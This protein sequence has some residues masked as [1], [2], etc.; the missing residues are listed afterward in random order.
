MQFLRLSRF[1]S[2]TIAA[3]RLRRLVLAFAASCTLA[4]PAAAQDDGTA[5]IATLNGKPITERDLDMT[6]SDLQDQLGQVPEEGRRAAAL[7]ALIDIRSLATKAEA[8]GMDQTDEFKDRMAFLRQ[9][10]LHNTYFRDEIVNKVTDEEVR[11]RYDK[12]VAATPPENEVRARH[13]LL[14]TE[15]EAK[16]VIAE[17]DAGADFETVAKEKSTGPSGPNGGDLGYFTRGR[18][19]PEFENAAF[20]LDVGAY[21]ETPVHTQ[22]GWHVIKLEDKR[23]VQPPAFAD[24]EG[25]IRSVLLRERYFNLLTKL[26]DEASIDISDPVLKEAFDKASAAQKQSVE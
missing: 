23:L 24:V 9:R 7:M 1:M 19:V 8:A 5:V 2:A 6:F 20:A 11:A 16:A 18:M 21:T 22:F 10:A 26:R 17:L 15:E 25:Q 3:P 14:G 4:L 12:E 13:I